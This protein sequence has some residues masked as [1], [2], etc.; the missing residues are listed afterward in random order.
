MSV[1]GLARMRRGIPVECATRLLHQNWPRSTALTPA[2]IG[3]GGDPQAV[4]DFLGLVEALSDAGFLSYEALVFN[5]DGPMLVDAALTARGRAVLA[6]QIGA[7][8]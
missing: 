5:S 7:S 6:A 3:L 4:A 8:N 2:D 1:D